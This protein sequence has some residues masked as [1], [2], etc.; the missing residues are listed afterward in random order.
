MFSGENIVFQLKKVI[1]EHWMILLCKCGKN[2]YL[3]Q[4]HTITEWTCHDEEIG[5]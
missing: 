3:N 1:N 2:V 4:V 5:S